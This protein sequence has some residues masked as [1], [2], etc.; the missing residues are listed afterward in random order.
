MTY[1]SLSRPLR[2]SIFTTSDKAFTL[3]FSDK[4]RELANINEF[5]FVVGCWRTAF[6]RQFVEYLDINGLKERFGV[7]GLFDD[8]DV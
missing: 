7:R 8:N 3:P 6:N 5:T 4:W 2:N 1:S